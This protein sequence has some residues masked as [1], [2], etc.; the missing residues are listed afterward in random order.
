VFPKPLKHWLVSA[1]KARG[2]ELKELDR[3]LRGFDGCLRHARARGLTPKTVLDVGV[4]TGTPWL[5]EA[6][7]DAKLALFEPLTLFRPE[8]EQLAARYDADVHAVALSDTIGTA[9]FNVNI[10]HP[11]SSSLLQMD[12]HFAEYAARVQARH[13]YQRETVPVDTLDHLNHYEPPYVLKL[14][15]EGAEK[16]VLKGAQNTLRHTEFLLTEISVLRRQVGEPSF[17]ELIDFLAECDFE[18]FD[19]PCIAQ[20]KGDGQLIYLDAAFV[21]RG[22]YLW[23]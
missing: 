1:L 12:P 13:R 23:P 18:L 15:V 14:D 16:Q 17:A 7:L 2:Y 10:G 20:A 5:Y 6:F 9:D 11:T 4:G 19:I 21:Q 3:P 8:L 22:S